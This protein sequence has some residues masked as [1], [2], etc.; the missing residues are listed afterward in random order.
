MIAINFDKLIEK[1]PELK[2]IMKNGE[3]IILEDSGHPFAKIVPF[4]QPKNRKLGG[5]KGKIWMSDDFNK[6]L[7]EDMLKE[8]YK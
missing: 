5:E 4:H 1:I 2:T 6:P 7:P 3:E 8:F